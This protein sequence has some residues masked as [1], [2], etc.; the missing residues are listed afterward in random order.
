M[1][2]KQYLI[3][4]QS[5]IKQ[6]RKIGELSADQYNNRLINIKKR[7]IYTG[8]NSLTGDMVDQ[9]NGIYA[10]KAN[11]YERTINHYIEFKSYLKNHV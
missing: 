10:N 3:N 6:C 7:G 9:I 11:V 5:I 8:E 2:F 4:R 1:D